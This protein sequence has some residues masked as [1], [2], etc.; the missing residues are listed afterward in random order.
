[1]NPGDAEVV[2]T[3]TASELEEGGERH[4]APDEKKKD[5][6]NNKLHAI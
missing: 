3:E 1:M 6:Q 5:S 2:D 4:K